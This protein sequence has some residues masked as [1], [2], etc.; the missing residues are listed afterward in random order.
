MI[1]GEKVAL[2]TIRESD[3]DKLLDLICDIENRGDYVPLD[4][5]SQVGIRKRFQEDGFLG[6]NESTLLICAADRIVGTVS[7]THA[8]HHDGLEL[9]YAVFD[10][11]DRNKGYAT[12]ALSLLVKFLFGTKK[13]NRL[14][15]SIMLG[16][17][18][19]KRVA[20]KCG[21]QFEGTMRG[22]VF[23]RGA[24]QDMELYSLLRAEVDAL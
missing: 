21:F 4:L 17:S 14:Q 12:D 15:V 20:E 13:I 3:I 16:N 1:R 2:R 7:F 19:S 18:A 22:A 5:P 9:G 6:S 8:G 11:K 23:H 10:E 24:Y